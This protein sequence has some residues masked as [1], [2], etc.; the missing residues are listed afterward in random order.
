MYDNNYYIICIYKKN[1]LKSFFKIIFLVTN[2]L[3]THKSVD[4]KIYTHQSNNIYMYIYLN[5]ILYF[6]TRKYFSAKIITSIWTKNKN[7][8]ILLLIRLI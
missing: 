2:I 5:L 4:K 6:H 1:K 8:Y 3:Y 7:N